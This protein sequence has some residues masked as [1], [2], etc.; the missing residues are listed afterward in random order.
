[1]RAAAQFED[2]QFLPLQDRAE[3]Q[4]PVEV[5]READ[6]GDTQRDVADG[7]RGR[8]LFFGYIFQPRSILIWHKVLTQQR[9]TPGITRHPITLLNMK[10]FVSAVGCM[11]FLLCKVN[12]QAA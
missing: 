5:G 8:H 10:S 9:L 11:P 6:V 12:A 3:S 1:M 7:Y 4:G 2:R